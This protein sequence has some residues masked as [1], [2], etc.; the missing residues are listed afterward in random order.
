M[1][2]RIGN[3]LRG[4]G[5]A[6]RLEGDSPLITDEGH[7]IYHL[8]LKLINDPRALSDVLLNIAGVVETGLFL[9]LADQVVI[10]DVNGSTEI[11]GAEA[12]GSTATKE[13]LLAVLRNLKV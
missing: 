3:T 1:L 5:I 11:F 4:R 13:E 9:G 6:L 12:K 10:G 8:D 7:H 2:D